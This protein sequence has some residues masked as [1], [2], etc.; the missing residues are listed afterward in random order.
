MNVDIIEGDSRPV[1]SASAVVQG[2][3]LFVPLHGIIDLEAERSRLKKE[4]DRLNGVM[5]GIQTKL[6]NERFLEK[7][8]AQVV[9]KEREKLADITATVE[10]LERSLDVLG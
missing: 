3:E 7:A 2:V 10:K 9:E 5:S 8:P 1:P 4:I 6:G